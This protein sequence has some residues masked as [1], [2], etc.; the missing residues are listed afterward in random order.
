[1]SA[2]RKDILFALAIIAFL[3]LF[4]QQTNAMSAAAANYPR[5]LM[6]F[7]GFL[8]LIMLIQSFLQRHIK[9]EKPAPVLF[10]RIGIFVA[11]LVAYVL[12]MNTVGYFFA[13]PI[14]VVIGCALLRAVSLRVSV[15]IGVGF[16]VFIYILFVKFLHLPVPLGLLEY[17]LGG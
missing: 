15:C 6:G 5:L 12:S 3:V 14:F 16:S 13:T 10:A 17:F 11:L 4:W 2:F 1:M 8:T 7:I 9:E